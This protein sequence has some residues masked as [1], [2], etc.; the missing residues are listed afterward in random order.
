M[1]ISSGQVDLLNSNIVCL[2]W[3][4]EMYCLKFVSL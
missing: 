2:F 3:L 4:I 1:K